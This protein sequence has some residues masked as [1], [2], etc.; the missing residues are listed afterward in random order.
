MGDRLQ[1]KEVLGKGNDE[2]VKI[3]GEKGVLLGEKRITHKY[4]YDWK[5]NQPVMT[6][7]TSQWFCDLSDVKDKALKALDSVTFVPPVC[8]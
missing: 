7:A 8:E 5:T 1:N 4:P 3:L 6:R 2:M